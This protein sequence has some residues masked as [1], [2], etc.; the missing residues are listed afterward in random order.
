[1]RK[2]LIFLLSL[3]CFCN[4]ALA[5]EPTAGSG[6]GTG[7]SSFD[8]KEEEKKDDVIILKV[9]DPK[10]GKEIEVEVKNGQM[11]DGKIF[12]GVG[13]KK[14]NL[15]KERAIKATKVPNLKAP[16]G[17]EDPNAK[18]K[19]KFSSE[20]VP[21]LQLVENMRALKDKI[22]FD[23]SYT[24]FSDDFG[25]KFAGTS[26]ATACV[27]TVS[28]AA[29]GTPYGSV[30]E[31][32]SG[33]PFRGT[34][35]IIARARD[36]GQ[37]I[38]SNNGTDFS[39]V[40]AYRPLPGDIAIVASDKWIKGSPEGSE[41]D[42]YQHAIMM[43]YNDDGSIG[44]IHNSRA[45]TAFGKRS[46]D[47]RNIGSV[48]EQ[49][50]EP[51][52]Y[53]GFP[54]TCYITTSGYSGGMFMG[55]MFDGLQQLGEALNKIIERFSGLAIEAHDK[56]RPVAFD[57]ITSL[58]IIDLALSIIMA[59]FEINPNTL[60]VKVLKYGFIYWIYAMWPT[61]VDTF[62]QT[63][64]VSVN[65]TVSPDTFAVAAENI[66]QP[67]FVLQK[68][69]YLIK[70]GF[71]YIGSMNWFSFA[72]KIFTG[73]SLFLLV[74]AIATVIVMFIYIVSYV[75]ISFFVYA[76]LSVVSVPFMS[77]KFTKFFPEGAIG[78]AWNAMIRMMVVTFMLGLMMYLFTGADYAQ[79]GG[80][81][82]G[83]NTA[84]TFVL[85]S[86]DLDMFIWYLKQCTVLSIFVF[87]VIKI[88]NS[89][90]SKLGGRF[91]IAL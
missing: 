3:L 40:N 55:N 27:Y 4:I 16:A 86:G 32:G 79:A 65:E 49:N 83:V 45:G 24:G 66:C 38:D 21:G 76:A 44:F 53:F 34:N 7:M 61:I 51:E 68:V 67:Q 13:R 1:M 31:D 90:V 87:F 85:S 50:M 19:D 75:Y 18:D 28:T 22:P 60:F 42:A 30:N 2:F 73:G 64:V 8:D 15:D 91:E 59:G 54:V 29:T 89:I 14:G 84:N 63:L 56:I 74:A 81:V 82:N 41:N 12:I 46:D 78:G 77:S 9:K 80:L 39:L 70:P 52:D 62:F 57:L 10:T 69:M 6:A 35:A 25:N 33:G 71:D 37:A 26:G 47:G 43:K 88:T 17:K 11:P 36:L 5:D 20:S 72:L 23:L 58:C 48:N